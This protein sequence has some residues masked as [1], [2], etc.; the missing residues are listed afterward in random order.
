MKHRIARINLTPAMKNLSHGTHAKDVFVSHETVSYNVPGLA[1]ILGVE[2]TL[3]HEGYGI[4]GMTDKD[5]HKAWANAMGEAIFWH[6]GNANDYATGVENVSE[7]PLLIAAKK[8]THEQAH[9]MWMQR[10]AQLSALAILMAC[11]HNVHPVQRPLK[12]T[13]G[14]PGH[15]GVCSHW[16]LS[17]WDPGAEGH[18]DCWPYD[19]GGYFPL[20]HVIDLAKHFAKTYRF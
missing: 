11:W 12:R 14:K 19:K 13:N 3:V 16:D 7:I 10:H 5:G 15:P 6:C 20:D 17:Q 1:D 9:T 2:T 8:I 18:W 4:H